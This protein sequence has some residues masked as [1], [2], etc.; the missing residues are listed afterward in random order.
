MLLTLK[1]KEQIGLPCFCGAFLDHGALRQ[2]P[3]TT[4]GSPGAA[5]QGQTWANH[6]AGG[7]KTHSEAYRPMQYL[8][9]SNKVLCKYIPQY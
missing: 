6:F 9:N 8:C 4:R 7:K 5:M 1:K 2:L 3:Q